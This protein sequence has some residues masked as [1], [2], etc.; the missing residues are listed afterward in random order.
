MPRNVEIKAKVHDV[1]GLLEKA[2]ILSKEEPVLLEQEDIFYKIPSGRLK[3]RSEKGQDAT[4]LFYDRPDVTGPKLCDYSKCPIPQGNVSVLKEV[5]SKALGEKGA[6]KKKRLLLMVEQTRIHIDSVE[7][8]GDFMELEVV[9]NDDQ[10]AEDGQKIADSLME[11]LGVK[12]EDLL[13]G[14][15]FD[16]L[17]KS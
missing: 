8:L 3:L 2:K 9:L 5:L 1:G 14:A 17:P 12:K 13:E 16:M 7:G 11:K 10:S 4:L 15:Y 6:V